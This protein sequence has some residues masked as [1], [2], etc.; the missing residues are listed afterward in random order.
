MLIECQALFQAQHSAYIIH[1]FLTRVYEEGII[2]SS[3]LQMRQLRHKA[4]NNFPK[5]INTNAGGW[6]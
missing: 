5:V 6:T 2:T 3:I 4:V 1:L